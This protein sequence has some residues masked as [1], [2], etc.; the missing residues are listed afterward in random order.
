MEGEIPPF[1]ILKN[2]I[3]RTTRYVQNRP[4]KFEVN[5]TAKLMYNII[6]TFKFFIKI[7]IVI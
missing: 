2:Y 1:L 3:G 5:G 6:T 7:K 4:L